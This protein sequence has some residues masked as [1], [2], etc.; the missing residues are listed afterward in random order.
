MLV[1]DAIK[2]VTAAKNQLGYVM[3]K[4]ERLDQ[5]SEYEIDKDLLVDVYIQGI[6]EEVKKK[7]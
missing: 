5:Q 2:A 3:Y 6:H 4:L 7:C 1:K